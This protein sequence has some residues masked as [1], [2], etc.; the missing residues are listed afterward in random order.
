MFRLRNTQFFRISLLAAVSVALALTAGCSR[1]PNVR[2]HKYLESGK[3][4]AANGKYK[5]AG[6]QFSNAL[7]IDK[8][9]GDAHFELAK[10]YLKMGSGMPAYHELLRTVDLLPQNLEARVDLG[11]ILMLGRP[12]A[13]DRATDQANAVL[14]INPNYADAYALLSGIARQKGDTAEAMKDIER[15]IALDPSKAVYHVEA[16]VLEAPDP[17]KEGMAESELQKAASLDTKNSTPHQVLA[18][19]LEKKGDL[20]GAEREYEAAIAVAPNDLRVRAE[21]AGLY[22]RE[23]SKDKTEQ[24]LRQATDDL[25]NNEAACKLL[26]DFY[27]KE[28]GLDRAEHA[29]ADLTAKHP[30]D[31]QIKLMYAQVLVDKHNFTQ[32]AQVAKELTKVDGGDARVQMLNALVL[33]NGG[34]IND[35]FELLEK[36]AKDS[37]N[38]V[39]LQ[40]L[41]ARVAEMNGNTTVSEASYRAAGKLDPGNMDALSGLADMAIRH[42]DVGALSDVADEMIKDHKD[43]LKGYFLR[44][45]VEATRKEYDKAV[46]DYQTVLKIDPNN[47]GAYLEMGQMAVAQGHAAEGQAL[48]EKTLERDPN[49]VRGLASIVELDMKA[50]QPDKALARVKEQ[51]A[52]EPGNGA[53]YQTLAYIQ[54]QMK[55]YKD[56]ADNAQKAMQ[57]LPIS[58]VAVKEYAQAEVAMGL[59]DPAI[60]VWEGWLTRHPVDSQA[61]AI[62]GSLEETKGDDAKAMD[63]YKKTL[64]L[65]GNNAVASNNLAYLMV[66]NGQNADVA[67]TLAQAARRSLPDSPE[68]AD[69]LAWVNYYEGN[70]S[71]AKD[72][73]E[74]AVKTEPNNASFHFHLGMVYSKLNDKADAT[75]HLKKAAS[76]APND[77]AGKQ[78]AMELSKLG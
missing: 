10:L 48:F 30:K 22:Y 61:M 69:T 11:N 37:P 25:P 4:Y 2:K 13:L 29:F 57:L 21:L 40:L 63:Y 3:K 49:S 31:I 5:E 70:Y 33:V 38:N 28:G 36:S 60:T 67:L 68:S 50:K 43:Q 1:D 74:G 52:K 35:A 62:L 59:I 7:R 51:L 42:N 20:Q 78:A 17:A 55:D 41:L 75:T 58:T 72:L 34:K 27:V 76:L 8:N 39:P 19:L 73:L 23:G 47:A 64:Q 66:E 53:F 6:I 46:A 18:S 32:A 56:A 12:P 71:E 16:A 14:A 26:L 9:Y 65:D 54:L 44:G 45:T 77:K 15:A 24:T